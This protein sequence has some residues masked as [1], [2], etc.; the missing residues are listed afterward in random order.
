[1]RI[2]PLILPVVALMLSGCFSSHYVPI[3]VDKKPTSREFDASIDSTWSAVM[4][5]MAEF[6]LTVIE[7]NSGILNTD[8]MTRTSHR[9]AS[10]WRGLAFGGQVQ[11][12]VPI[13]LME[14]FNILVTRNLDSTTVVRVIRYV[15]A[16]QY[17]QAMGGK[18]SWLPPSTDFVQTESST[19]PEWKLLNAIERCIT[20]G[21][22]SIGSL[23]DNDQVHI[24]TP[25]E[26]SPSSGT[27]QH[28]GR[29]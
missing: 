10:V 1:M 23:D 2:Q 13:E 16:R 5:V 17:T 14:R 9:P 11:E 29:R 15:K 21:D 7:K 25:A 4:K 24:V 3:T 28:R 6:P 12:D 19:I 18:G 8:W 27:D 26:Q 20:T 22:A